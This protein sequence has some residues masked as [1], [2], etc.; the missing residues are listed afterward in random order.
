MR[1]QELLKAFGWNDGEQNNQQDV[2][3]FNC[4]LSDL[5][6]KQMEKTNFK[7]TYSSLFQGVL[8]NVV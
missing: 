1:T 2:N 3:E 5:L 7:G 8:E 4:I 6:E